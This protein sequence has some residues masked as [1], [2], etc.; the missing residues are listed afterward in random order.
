MEPT[1]FVDASGSEG[2][3]WEAFS[4]SYLHNKL[5]AL[6]APARFTARVNATWEESS[7]Y[8]SIVRCGPACAVILYDVASTG[9]NI[10]EKNVTKY[11]FSMRIHVV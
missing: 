8:C 4:I 7:A 1:L 11:G 6:D 5:A 3:S 9:A 10:F 2:Q